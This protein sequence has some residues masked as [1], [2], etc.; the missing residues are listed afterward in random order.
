MLWPPGSPS[1]IRVVLYRYKALWLFKTLFLIFFLIKRK[2]TNKPA[3]SKR[4]AVQWWD[5]VPRRL[6]LRSPERNESGK[7]VQGE[8][9]HLAVGSATADQGLGR[10]R[11]RA[12]VAEHCPF[13][14]Q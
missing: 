9:L 8:R 7:A 1:K 5:K 4:Q 10:S 2:G 12:A 14:G 11:S 13:Q 3:L 6:V